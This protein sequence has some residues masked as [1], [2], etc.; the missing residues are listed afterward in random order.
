M[1]EANKGRGTSLPDASAVRSVLALLT[2]YVDCELLRRLGEH[3][4]DART[5]SEQMARSATAIRRR[6]KRL[7]DG[8]LVEFERV[9]GRNVYCL[10]KAVT[11]RNG[12]REVI[13]TVSTGRGS[14]IKVR[15]ARSGRLPGNARR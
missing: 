14:Q 9:R 13:L 4:A 11:V 3:P 7:A 8:D 5:L 15:M 1:P 6:L 2:S 12:R 10:A